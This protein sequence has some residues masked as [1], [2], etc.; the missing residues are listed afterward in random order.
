MTLFVDFNMRDQQGRVPALL[1][2]V[3]AQIVP[4]ETVWAVDAEG[5]RCKAVVDQITKSSPAIAKLSLEGGTAE[6]SLKSD[7]I[8]EIP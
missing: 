6:P 5:N 2:G 3:A 1:E 8:V 7:W 4:G